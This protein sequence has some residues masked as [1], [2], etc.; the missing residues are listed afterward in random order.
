MCV[1]VSISFFIKFAYNLNDILTEWSKVVIL[2]SILHI[3][4]VIE[5]TLVSIGRVEFMDLWFY[6][7]I[8]EQIFNTQQWLIF[9]NK[10]L[11]TPLLCSYT[12]SQLFYDDY[13]LIFLFWNIIGTDKSVT[14][15]SNIHSTASIN[16]SEIFQIMNHNIC[17]SL[18]VYQIQN[19]TKINWYLIGIETCYQSLLIF[20]YS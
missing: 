20:V 19:I 11:M 9:T 2:R 8:C 5:L 15:N 7:W 1:H 13:L 14:H 6:L 4:M 17:C 18:T 10:S 3:Y 12:I 16:A